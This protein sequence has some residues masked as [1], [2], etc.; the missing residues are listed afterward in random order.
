MGKTQVAVEYSIKARRDPKGFGEYSA[1]LF[2]SAD[3]E[4]S[5][6]IADRGWREALRADPVLALGLNTHDGQVT[7]PSVAEAHGMAF[8]P[9]EEVLA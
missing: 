6:E 2:V 8:V 4:Q 7:Y 5:L 1:F 3:T 9:L